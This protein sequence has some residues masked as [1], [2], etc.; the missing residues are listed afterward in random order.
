[1]FIQQRDSTWWFKL[2]GAA[3]LAIVR[4]TL[5]P[6]AKPLVITEYPKSGGT[7]LSQMLS[8]AIGIPYPRNRLPHLKRQ[9][10][11]GCYLNT[12]QNTDT[13]VVWRDGRDIM[14]SFYYHL[15]FEKPITSGKYSRKVKQMLGVDDPR[16]IRR[17]LPDFIDW[18]FN[19]GY[20]GFSWTDFVDRWVDRKDI[21]QTSYESVTAN[22]LNELQTALRMLGLLHEN[23]SAL[24]SIVD[25]YSFENQTSRKPG[26]EDVTEFVRKG[27]VGDWKNAFNATARET[28]NHHAG[29]HL[30]RLG[31]EKDGSWV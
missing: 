20:P 28:F 25:E 18:T 12:G 16:D 27:I 6:F 31:Y 14:V 1:M 24:E 15:M 26:E 11:H 3:R 21:H 22:P 19:G 8:A 4:G 13:I 7:W 10:I 2:N 9:I 17:H 23:T 29:K 5:G 30:I